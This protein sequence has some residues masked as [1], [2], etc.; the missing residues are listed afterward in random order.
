MSGIGGV[1]RGKVLYTCSWMIVRMSG[2]SWEDGLCVCV[3][4]EGG[5]NW[6]WS[7]CHGSPVLLDS[8]PELAIPRLC[9]C[10]LS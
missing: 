8:V 10:G 9:C 4:G 1:G 6:M 2:T 7:R 5:G 3:W